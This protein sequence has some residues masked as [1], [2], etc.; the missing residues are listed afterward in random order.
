[1]LKFLILVI[2]IVYND[3][4]ILT[5]P[6]LPSFVISVIFIVLS[7]HILVIPDG[8]TNVT[9]G[10]KGFKGIDILLVS[11]GNLEI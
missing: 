10:V 1:M 3:H 11:L 6:L 9:P 4:Y 2:F 5:R 7:S 8:P